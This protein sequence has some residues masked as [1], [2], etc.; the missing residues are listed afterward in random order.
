MKVVQLMMIYL[1]TRASS[2]YEDDDDD[3]EDYIVDM[4]E[5]N[6]DKA[7]KEN[8]FI[9]VEFTSPSCTYCQRIEPA[10][11]DAAR[12]LV[13]EDARATIKFARLDATVSDELRRKYGV[14]SYPTF[15]LF[16]HETPVLYNVFCLYCLCFCLCYSSACLSLSS[17]E[18]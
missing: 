7:I 18:V 8:P 14:A 9:F 5:A 6:L 17:L 3:D 11:E 15:K 4:D 16:R 2:C 10:Y 12:Q 1:L 13:K